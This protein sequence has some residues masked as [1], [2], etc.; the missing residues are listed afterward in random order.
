LILFLSG[1]Q[2]AANASELPKCV[3][4]TNAY[5]TAS[6]INPQYV[7]TVKDA[8]D[9]DLG[10][11]S[12]Q[13]FSGSTDV[14]FAAP[15]FRSIFKLNKWGETIYF[16]L[17]NISQGIYVP[18]L[19]VTVGKEP[20]NPNTIIL[21]GFTVGG[22]TP[23]KPLAT[24]KVTAL[25]TPSPAISP[26]KPASSPSQAIS[27]RIYRADKSW[28][29]WI[30]SF[31]YISGPN[32]LTENR[33]TKIRISGSCTPSGKTIQVMK[34]RSDNGVKYPNGMRYIKPVL[35]CTSGNFSGI[36]KVT[37]DTR[38]SITELPKSHLGTEILFRLNQEIIPT[39]ID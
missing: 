31:D 12:L 30:D 2:N 24:P 22:K 32:P 19:S 26:S 4:V 34:N 18:R 1:V 3:Q 33:S 38:I 21:N 13:F 9:A 15:Q 28:A 5:V 36:L 16:D 11:V 25:N 14:R 29:A 27:A 6:T 39:K 35:T 20:W 23:A 37:G 10:S 17:G 7:V 8:C